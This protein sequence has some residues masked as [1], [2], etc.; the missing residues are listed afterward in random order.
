M[1]SIF[2]Q[3]AYTQR[4]LRRELYLF[5]LYRLLEASLLA[6]V[7]FGP[8]EALIGEARDATLATATCLAYVPAAILLLVWSRRTDTRMSEVALVGVCTDVIVAALVT[9]AVPQA[10]PGVA[11]MLVFNLGAAALFLRL[12][13]GLAVAGFASAA[14]LVQFVWD[15][16]D[17]RS[18]D[19]PLAELL[20]F[21]FSFFAMVTLTFLLGE[22]LR[23]SQDLADRRGAE[24][25]GLAGINELII[26][27]MGTGVLMVD[28]TRTVR[29]ANEAALQLY[30]ES[31]HGLDGRS[32]Q[33]VS[34]ELAARLSHWLRKGE[35]DD[36]PMPYGHEQLEVQPRFT[37][38]FN[39]S[40]TVLV[41]LD[42][43]SLVSRRA[44][45][46]TL[47]A[48]GR[49]SASLA[50]EVRNP[51]AAINYSVQ[52]LEESPDLPD[53][54]R[55]LVEIIHQQCQRTN[56][57]I[58]SVL[59]LAR[60][61]RAMGEQ[62]ELVAYVRRFVEEFTRTMTPENG[63]LRATSRERPLAGVF[64][65]GH[66]HQVLTILVQNAINYGRLPGEPAR[67]TVTADERDGR[68]AVEVTDRGPGVP[69]AIAAQLG[70][71][72]FTTS[73][74]GTGLGLYIA[75]ELCR[76][77]GASLDYVPVPGG[78]ACFRVTLA[79]RNP[80]LARDRS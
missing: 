46:L 58:E 6:L 22:R 51:L 44:E 68:P 35:P 16:L 29:L 54:D 57:I 33:E 61:E 18:A 40:D 36:S 43:A 80:L 38:L 26:R 59:G 5:A 45:S 79:G 13:A 24:A 75:R 17:G 27:R 74:H 42:D 69:D 66:L 21:T 70:R 32:L 62:L 15:R 31:E 39:D 64:D 63:T 47:S 55:R 50:H 25:E 19:R 30:G 34:P 7:V 71:P 77:N 72:F 28:G 1:P 12:Q 76:A 14:L 11:L 52:L 10:V 67:I 37:R 48:M 20:M 78:G 8:G 60:R 56:G 41:F 2:A 23:A 73:E 4:V 3:P 9:H 53:S 49:F 65:P